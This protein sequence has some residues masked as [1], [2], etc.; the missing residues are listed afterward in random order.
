MHDC[1][2]RS[3]CRHWQA[4]GACTYRDRCHFAHGAEEVR[5]RGK[6]AGPASPQPK[7]LQ[8]VSSPPLDMD[9]AALLEALPWLTVQ[10]VATLPTARRAPLPLVRSDECAI[11]YEQMPCGVLR[12]LTCCSTVMC[13]NCSESVKT[14]MGRICPLFC[15]V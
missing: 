7:A 5:R 15:S 4:R 14:K 13:P 10:P 6:G 8:P 1:Y 9:M 3:L 11:C 2:K 12:R